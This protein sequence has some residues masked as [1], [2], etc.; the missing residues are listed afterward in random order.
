MQAFCLSGFTPTAVS[1]RVSKVLQKHLAQ[2][3]SLPFCSLEWVK[4]EDGGHSNVVE[5]RI[6]VP[7]DEVGS[8]SPF[9][10]GCFVFQ[11]CVCCEQYP[12]EAPQVRLLTRVLSPNFDDNGHSCLGKHSSLW[13]PATGLNGLAMCCYDVLMEP[14]FVDVANVRVASVWGSSVQKKKDWFSK[15]REWTDYYATHDAVPQTWTPRTHQKFP[16]QLRDIARTCLVMNKRRDCVLS[17]LP[18]P[19]VHIIINKVM[20]VPEPIV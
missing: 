7:H 12:L 5:C 3:C 19:V 17:C 8:S 4:M 10:G 14:N 6:C 13:S 11:F 18:K 15:A 2:G 20:I 16:R 9:A 1:N